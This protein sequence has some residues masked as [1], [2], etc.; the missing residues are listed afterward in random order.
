MIQKWLAGGMIEPVPEMAEF[1]STI[2]FK[3][4]SGFSVK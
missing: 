1:C 2:L 3:G 4:L